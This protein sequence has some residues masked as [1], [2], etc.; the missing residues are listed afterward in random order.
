MSGWIALAALLSNGEIGD[1]S[2]FRDGSATY[3]AWNRLVAVKDGNGNLLELV[4]RASTLARDWLG[5][6]ENLMEHSR[7]FRG[8]DY[9]PVILFRRRGGA[10]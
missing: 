6:R 4:G 9:L 8:Q 5:T 7:L 3:D 1:A 10:G 2:L